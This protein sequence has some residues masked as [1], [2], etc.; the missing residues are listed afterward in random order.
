MILLLL[1]ARL[2]RRPRRLTGV[3]LTAIGVIAG[4]AGLLVSVGIAIDGA[5]VLL[6]GLF[7]LASLRVD[8]DRVR[9]RIAA[10]RAR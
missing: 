10:L 2:P 4:I 5:I 1:L 8:P 6:C 9:A 7:L 3:A